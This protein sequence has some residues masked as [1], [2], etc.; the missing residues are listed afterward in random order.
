MVTTCYHL[1]YKEV[2]RFLDLHLAR[3]SH[4]L[5]RFLIELQTLSRSILT[6]LWPLSFQSKGP[7]H[8][9]K[10]LTIIRLPIYGGI[11]TR[12]SHNRPM[13]KGK[14]ENKLYRLN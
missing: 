9:I 13:I 14:I 5:L 6:I 7:I 2:I 4:P 11:K 1:V 10:W 12:N 8:K 3:I